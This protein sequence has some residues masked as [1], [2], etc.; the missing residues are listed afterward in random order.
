MTRKHSSLIFEKRP[1]DSK[2]EVWLFVFFFLALFV[3]GGAPKAPNHV[4]DY[5]TWMMAA[6]F[7]IIAVVHLLKGILNR[8]LARGSAVVED[9]CVR[10]YDKGTKGA[11]FF[12]APY[13]QFRA[14]RVQFDDSGH[15]FSHYSAYL[16]PKE[17]TRK[18]GLLSWTTL[19]GHEH[20]IPESIRNVSDEM[21]IPLE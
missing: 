2:S 18:V 13:S 9:G 1:S 8:R 19:F 15:G 20:E 12:E 4:G 5:V 3:W 17:S 10:L 11:P 14:V 16:I 6:L 7:A 21:G